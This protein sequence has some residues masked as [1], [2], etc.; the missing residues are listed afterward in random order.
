MAVTSKVIKIGSWGL[1]NDD[2]HPYY[3]FYHQL[4]EEFQDEVKKIVND[5]YFT[6]HIRVD[7]NK[8]IISTETKL[9]LDVLYEIGDKFNMTLID[10]PIIN[11]KTYEFEIEYDLG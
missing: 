7:S 10:Y 3:L 6:M 4:L 9:K 5:K 1:K 8:L 2:H 11:C